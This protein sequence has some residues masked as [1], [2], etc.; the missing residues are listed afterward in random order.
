M[1]KE[2]K[3]KMNKKRRNEKQR[4]DEN[5]DKKRKKHLK[6][7]KK[8]E[9]KKEKRKEGPKGVT[10]REG[11]KKNF[12]FAWVVSREIVTKLKQKNQIFEHPN[13]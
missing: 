1:Q 11:P 13:N 5:E 2:Q 10:A 12:F 6:K 8:K 9:G 7:H 4:N 3:E